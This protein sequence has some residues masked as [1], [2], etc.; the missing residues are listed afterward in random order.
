MLCGH[1]ATSLL[2]ASL[3]IARNDKISLFCTCALVLL[4]NKGRKYCPDKTQKK[5]NWCLYWKQL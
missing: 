2:F 3:F 4:S 1:G 5:Y